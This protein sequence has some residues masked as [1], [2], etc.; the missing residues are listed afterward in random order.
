MRCDYPGPG[1]ATR[2]PP[3]L[4]SAAR[5]VSRRRSDP[6]ERARLAPHFTN[7]DGPVFAL[8]EPA[9]D[10]QGRA[11]RPLLALSGHAA[12]A[13][14]RR[15]RR[16]AARG[17]GGLRRRR[18]QAGGRA[19]RA[20]LRRLRRRLGGPAR[21]RARGLRVGAR[22]SSPRSSSARGWPPTSSSRRATSPT[23]RRCPAAATATTATRRSAREYAAAMDTLFA[24]TPRRSRACARG[25]TRR[26]PRAEGEPDA[27]RRRAVN[28][29]ALDLLRGLLPAASLSHMGIYA[30]GQ[31]YE[32]LILHLLGHPLPE[33]RRYGD[34]ILDAI[35]AVMP[36]F[37]AR[38]ERPERGGEWIAYLERRRAAAERWAARL[39]LDRD[40]GRRGP[41]VG[42]AAARRRRRGAPARR[43]AVRGRRA[44]RRSARAPP[45]PAAR[46]PSARGCSPTSSASARTAATAP[47][48]ASRRCATGS[49]SSRTT[50]RS[51]TS[52]ATAC[53]P[54]SGRR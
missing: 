17:A 50:A 25:S 8:V 48:A 6:A 41:A 29:K 27:A 4:R 3:A 21:R 47:A 44:P 36:S 5:A 49:R 34:M 28:A 45:S 13:V 35:K 19:L 1:P 11:V 38:V 30:T 40:D 9:G 22:T 32:Q 10:G 16:L 53:S 42:A 12:A 14:P 26:Y 23:T 2:Q 31:A 46:R 20:H 43:A 39:G 15:V 33:A 51:A 18:G 37:V 52:S 54:S 24:P 7:L